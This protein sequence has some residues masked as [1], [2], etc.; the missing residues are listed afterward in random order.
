MRKSKSNLVEW[1]SQAMAVDS[2][3]SIRDRWVSGNQQQNSHSEWRYSRVTV[4]PV[5]IVRAM[6]PGLF[7]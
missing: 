1:R 6:L 3:A 4:K 7:D 2:L 5:L